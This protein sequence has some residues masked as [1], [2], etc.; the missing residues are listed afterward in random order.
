[1]VDEGG[2]PTE[3]V[4]IRGD[5]LMYNKPFVVLSFGIGVK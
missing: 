1:M 3:L 4:Q 5:G 2:L